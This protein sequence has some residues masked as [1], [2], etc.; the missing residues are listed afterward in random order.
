MA[1]RTSST[2]Y[3]GPKN[4]SCLF[5]GKLVLRATFSAVCFLTSSACLF[6]SFCSISSDILD[7]IEYDGSCFCSC[8]LFAYHLHRSLIVAICCFSELGISCPK[9]NDACLNIYTLTRELNSVLF[10]VVLA[11]P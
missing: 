10:R 4:C 2:L 3:L 9:R 7:G 1:A 6:F 11:F 8:A 5:V